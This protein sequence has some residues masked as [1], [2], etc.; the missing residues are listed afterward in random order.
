VK[1]LAWAL[2]ALIVLG[3]VA[4]LALFVAAIWTYEHRFGETGIVVMFSLFGLIL[5]RVWVGEKR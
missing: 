3:F 4:V 1:F 5:A 2:N